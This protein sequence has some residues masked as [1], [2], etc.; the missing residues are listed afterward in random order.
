MGTGEGDGGEGE[1]V[2]EGGEREK[3]GVGPAREPARA[4]QRE[5]IWGIYVS[6]GAP[7]VKVK[8]CGAWRTRKRSRTRLSVRRQP[9]SG[10]QD[11]LRLRDS[12][13]K[14]H[15]RESFIE[16]FAGHETPIVFLRRRFDERRSCF[17]YEVASNVNANEPQQI[18]C[19]LP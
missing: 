3:Y 18:F 6:W 17:I 8:V 11:D 1:T 10:E 7:K 2:Y 16:R 14:H 5:R 19:V 12:G 4:G 15:R 13:S 9:A